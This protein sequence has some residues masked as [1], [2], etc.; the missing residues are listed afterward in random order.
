MRLSRW[1]IHLFLVIFLKLNLLEHLLL[2]MI[3]F[4]R[5]NI[6]FHAVHDS[7]KLPE[8]LLVNI[9][10]GWIELNVLILLTSLIDITR[11]NIL[12]CLIQQG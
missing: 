5:I 2:K 9:E 10:L 12:V 6:L 3:E 7:L 4:F 11:R 1:R 8:S